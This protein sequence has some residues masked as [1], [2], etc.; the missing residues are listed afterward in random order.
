MLSDLITFQ[1]LQDRAQTEQLVEL[2]RDNGIPAEIEILPLTA[3]NSYVQS[4][5]LKLQTSDQA[6]A[7]QLLQ[8][9]SEQEIDSLPADYYLYTFTKPELLEVIAQAHEW[10]E[11]DVILAK[12]L[13]EKQGENLTDQQ[14]STMQQARMQELAKAD[15]SPFMVELGYFCAILGGFLGLIV[16]WNLMVMKKT[17]PD[18]SKVYTYSENTRSHGKRIVI[19]GGIMFLTLFLIRMAFAIAKEMTETLY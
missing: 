2:L 1:I 14:I 10:S 12:K 7:T 15:Q 6:K 3:D 4:F 18:G 11:L 13:L 5:A 17:L 9:I 8:T 19:I 16:G